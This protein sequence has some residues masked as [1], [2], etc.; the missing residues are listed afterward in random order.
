MERCG[1]GARGLKGMP[2]YFVLMDGL[3]CECGRRRATWAR[4]RRA[5]RPR[6][7]PSDSAARPSHS[8]SRVS[9]I[10]QKQVRA[11]VGN[12]EQLEKEIGSEGEKRSGCVERRLGLRRGGVDDGLTYLLAVVCVVWLV[13]AEVLEGYRE[14]ARFTG[15][16]SQDKK[17]NHI[18][19][20]LR[21][22]C[23]DGYE[24]KYLIRGKNRHRHTF[25]LCIYIYIYKTT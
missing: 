3:L 17:V 19:K 9:L 16:K 15:N 7:A 8:T 22:V 13:C 23:K 14:I 18:T 12:A 25:P 11:V 2:H 4:S 24:A 1:V 10:S 6:S 5:A 21:R 20:M